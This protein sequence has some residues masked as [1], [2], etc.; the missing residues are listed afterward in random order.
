MTRIYNVSD[1]NCPVRRT[2]SVIGSKWTLLIIYQI[3]DR[4]IRFAQLRRQLPGISEKILSSQLQSLVKHGLVHR[5]S[6]DVVPPKV[7]YSLTPKGQKILP[8]L[9]QIEAFGLQSL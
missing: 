2:L 1:E 6:Y 3:N 9:Q 8:I 7:E 5:K 4:T